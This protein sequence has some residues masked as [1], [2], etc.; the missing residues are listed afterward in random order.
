MSNTARNAALGLLLGVTA[1]ITA[2]ADDGSRL[3]LQP[4]P[5]K[6]AVKLEKPVSDTLHIALS[7]LT[8]FKQRS[9]AVMTEKN[10]TDLG[11]EGF[12]IRIMD[13]MEIGRAHV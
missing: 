11:D 1:A 13:G 4:A 9:W 7:E 3:W 8:R 10:R 12:E 2:A 6:D 5:G